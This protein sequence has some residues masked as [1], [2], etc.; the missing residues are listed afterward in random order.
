[1]ARHV[2][3]VYYS[4]CPYTVSVVINAE[5]QLTEMFEW[6]KLNTCTAWT[7]RRHSNCYE[8]CFMEEND[9]I[10]FKVAWC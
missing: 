9:A 2:N 6:A 1:M 3:E 7:T 8:F 10:L 4:C 5:G